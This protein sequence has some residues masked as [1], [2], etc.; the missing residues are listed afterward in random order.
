MDKKVTLLYFSPTRTTNRNLRAI[1]KGMGCNFQEIDFT[2]PQN[3][4]QDHCFG[5]DDFVIVGSPV[6]GGVMPLLVREYLEQHIS[7][8]NTGCAVVAVYGNRHYDD[9]LV[10]MEDLM[11]EK[12]FIVTA[13]AACLGEHS[14]STQIATGRPDET[15]T[16]SAEGFG[17]KLSHKLES[18]IKPLEK[19]AIP[20]NRPYRERKTGSRLRPRNH[21]RLYPL[22]Y[23]RHQ[24]P[25]RSY[26]L[27]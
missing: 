13:A 19:G 11:T 26:R 8:K 17:A 27:R 25:C 9:C 1:A 20:G 4:Q 22:W 7:G 15:D 14:Y 21:Q 23:V 2:L 3:R 24:L 18:G 5:E 6:Y 16:A 12:G 10:E